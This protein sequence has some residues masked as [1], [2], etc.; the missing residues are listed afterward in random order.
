MGKI[1]FLERYK[2]HRQQCLIFTRCMGYYRP[3]KDFNKGKQSEFRERK[4]YHVKNQ[5]GC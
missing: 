5:G 3:V 4:F 2:E 1:E